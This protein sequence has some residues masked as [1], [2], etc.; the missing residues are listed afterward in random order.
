MKVTIDWLRDY[1][2][3]D[4]SPERLADRLTQAGLETEGI[5]TV[6]S[7]TVIELETTS[8]RPDHLGAL[9]VAREIAWICDA[10]LR[11]PVVAYDTVPTLDGKS[12][13]E[14][15]TLDVQDA[16]RC[17]RYIARLAVGVRVGPSPQWLVSRI[18][19][20]GLRTVNNVVDLSNY[21]LFEFG[22]PLHAFDFERV[23]AGTLIVRRAAQGEELNALNGKA[24][25]LDRDDLVIADTSRP[26]A[27]AGVMGGVDSEVG[28][29]TTK[30]L[31]ESAWFDPVPIRNTSRRLTLASDSSYRFERKVDPFGVDAASRR[32][33]SLLAKEAG[34][35]ILEGEVEFCSKDF[36]ESSRHRISLRPARVT[37]V[38]GVEIPTEDI[39]AG[40][41]RLGFEDQ[42]KKKKSSA[43]EF[44]TPSFRVD[45]TREIDLVEEVAR[46]YG[47]DNIPEGQLAVRAI[48]DNPIARTSEILAQLLV[49]AGYHEALTLAFTTKEDAAIESWWSATDPFEV[50]NP[51]RSAERRMRRS[52]LPRLLQA[53]R[54]NR[55]HGVETVRLFEQARVFHRRPGTHS[56]I[57]REHLGWCCHG[58]GSDFREMRGI[59][60]SVLRAMRIEGEIWTPVDGNTGGFQAGRLAQVSFAGERIGVVG[61][62]SL[63]GVPGDVWG[64]ELDLAPLFERSS[65]DVQFRE[66]SR[67]PGVRRDLNVIVAEEVPWR[68]LSDTITG[69]P[70]EH[71]TGLSF[72]DVYRGKQ[73]PKGQKSVLFSLS[74]QAED[75][76]LTGEEV[77]AQVQGVIEALAEKFG[78]ELRS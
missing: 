22:Q 73:V 42:T 63:D 33:L 61:A 69:R 78:A 67:H 17:P 40:L 16:T 21:V 52:L 19:A 56:P 38:L 35:V 6:G 9:G 18:E 27:L 64:G 72:G 53:V 75:R 12:I 30:I 47:F 57:E 28:D 55:L 77:D 58:E 3:F 23:D 13:A 62:V 68:E 10:P 20:L 8:N 2:D 49:G 5:E 71:F 39:R 31:L 26:V 7:E 74:F 25:L 11:P 66:F 48:P 32:F 36:L 65:A 60:E 51:V 46:V 24:Y 45:V 4:L 34:A 1:V 14:L 50:R 70:L 43:L 44:L 76:T 15:V 29:A 37:Q 54:G 41:I 59:A